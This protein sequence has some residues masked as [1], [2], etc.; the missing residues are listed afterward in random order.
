MSVLYPHGTAEADQISAVRRQPPGGDHRSFTTEVAAVSD[1]LATLIAGATVFGIGNLSRTNPVSTQMTAELATLAI[2]LLVFTLCVRVLRIHAPSRMGSLTPQIL[3]TGL[4][5]AISLAATFV[6]VWSVSQP[7]HLTLPVMAGWLGLSVWLFA[8]WRCL[9]LW[10]SG[11]A[12][13][14]PLMRRRTVIVGSPG[15]TRDMNAWFGTRPDA[16]FHVVG[17]F[18]PAAGIDRESQTPFIGGIGNLRSWCVRHRIRTVLIENSPTAGPNSGTAIGGDA[19]RVLDLI[20]GM[21]ADVRLLGRGALS[22]APEGA[23]SRF[24]DWLAVQ[25]RDKP[26]R[27]W[28]ELAKR[29]LD[30]LG[31]GALI[32]A[33]APLFG[34]IAAAVALESPGG[35]FFRQR[36]FGFQNEEISVLKFRSMYVTK[37]DVSGAQRTTR[38]DPRVTRVGRFLRRSSLDEIPQLFNVFMGTMSLVGPRPHATAMKVGDKLYHEAVPNYARR[39]RVKPGITGL[40]QV[41]GYRG[42]VDTL[43]HAQGRLDRDLRY[44]DSWSLALDLKIL[45]KTAGCVFGDRNAY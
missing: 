31:S 34:L 38:G 5:A 21:A 29:T 11:K 26:V 22:A 28:D 44:M 45:L 40:A 35:V 37:Q 20:D 42:E 15:F 10:F 39:H 32:V 8:G 25:V 14:R 7:I 3:R 12:S 4:A 6:I 41:S 2:N 36:R 27:N 18:D 33:L 19:E 9:V 13:F 16:E 43:D 24:G 1:H 17:S 23:I 30:V